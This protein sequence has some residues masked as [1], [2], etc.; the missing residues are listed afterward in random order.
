[1]KE[2]LK[3]I[4]EN[5]YELPKEGKMLVPGRLFVS[6]KLLENVEEICVQQVANVAQ[7][8]GIIGYSMAMSDVHSGYGFPIGGVAAFD[9][10]KGI[11]SPGGVGYDINCSVRLLATNLK[12]TDIKNK[13]EIV[14]SLF[15]TIPSGVGRGSKLK[16]SDSELDQVLRQGTQWAVKK[17]YGV[18][19][20]YFHTEEQGCLPGANPSAVSHKARARGRDQLG[21]LG[22]GNHFLEMQEV[23]E[24]YDGK[25]AKVF[26]LEKGQL[27]IMVHCGSRGL[28]HQVASD[29]IKLMEQE[30]KWPEQDRELI[31]APIKK[32][33]A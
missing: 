29:Y 10:E 17:G 14:H 25:V 27:T 9:T 15:R 32:K 8:P 4:A 1:M 28:G 26:G 12:L 23:V 6:P 21:T 22:A 30:Y 11:I 2:K 5:I 33:T 18:K 7:L 19:D 3:K 16:L 20:D 31:N 24:V 13:K